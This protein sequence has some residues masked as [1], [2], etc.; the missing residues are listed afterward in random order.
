MPEETRDIQK[1]FSEGHL[2]DEALKTRIVDNGQRGSEPRLARGEGFVQRAMEDAVHFGARL[3][4]VC[5]GGQQVLLVGGNLALPPQHVGAPREAHRLPHPCQVEIGAGNFQIGLAHVFQ[6]PGA[7]I[8]EIF[9]RRLLQC[10]Q[11]ATVVLE[12]RRT[13]EELRNLVAGPHIVGIDELL[14]ENFRIE[15]P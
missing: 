7:Q 6:R 5:P 13:L 9:R 12:I 14:G 15:G 10:V 11:H 8:S 1:I 2:I 3:T 4:A